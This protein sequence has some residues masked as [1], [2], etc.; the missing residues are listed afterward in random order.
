[1]HGTLYPRPYTVH[2]YV[3][4]AIKTLENTAQTTV[5]IRTRFP[6]G[7][8]GS[9]TGIWDL[10]ELLWKQ[11]QALFGI[12]PPGLFLRHFKAIKTTFTC[13]ACGD[14]FLH[15]IW[16]ISHVVGGFHLLSLFFYS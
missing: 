7:G 11:N 4:E 1:M 14:T 15:N 8:K 3:T 6:T 12:K 16:H 9:N 2:R 5:T 13:S 10:K